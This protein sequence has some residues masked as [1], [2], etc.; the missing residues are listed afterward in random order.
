M[1][2]EAA[3]VAKDL[4]VALMDKI[5]NLPTSSDELYSAKWVAS[6]YKVIYDAVIHSE[7]PA[8]QD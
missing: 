5:N 4:T 6:A 3:Q 2:F 1:A 8:K 7:Q